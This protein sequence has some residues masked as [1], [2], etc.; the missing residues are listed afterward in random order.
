MQNAPEPVVFPGHS[1]AQWA[2]AVS[3]FAIGGPFG[4]LLA[5]SISNKNGRR[6]AIVV[7]TWIFL[8]GGI[9]L[10]FAPNIYWLIPA[11]AII[12]FGCG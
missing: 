7:N 5:G 2:T 1:T 9:L 3:A 4:A 6:G 10:T 11:R 12:G 8:M